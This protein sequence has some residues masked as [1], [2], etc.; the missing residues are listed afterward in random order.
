LTSEALVNDQN[1]TNKTTEQRFVDLI[2]GVALK[3]RPNSLL[4]D[5]SSKF[6]FGK[7]GMSIFSILGGYHVFSGAP[8]RT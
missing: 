4:T 3:E 5:D 6:V 7:T 8:A 1:L 2:L